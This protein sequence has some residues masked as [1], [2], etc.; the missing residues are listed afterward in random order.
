MGG[1]IWGFTG[2]EG[3]GKSCCMTG[4]ALKHAAGVAHAYGY[5]TAEQYCM[6]P[7]NRKPIMCFDGF[8]VH[9]K[10]QLQSVKLSK[11][12]DTAQW[13]G[14]FGADEFK[15]ILICIDEVQNVMDSAQS[16]SV[17]ARLLNHAMAQR[18]RAGLG[19][20]Y[21]LQS[22][23]WLHKRLRWST[24]YLSICKDLSRTAWGKANGLKKGEQ[25]HMATFDCKGFITGKEWA[26]LKA[27]RVNGPKV[28][29]HYDSFAPASLIETQTVVQ[30]R[31]QMIDWSGREQMDN[32]TPYED[33]YM[34][35]NDEIGRETIYRANNYEDNLQDFSTTPLVNESYFAKVKRIK[36]SRG[37]KNG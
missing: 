35:R 20:M 9:G 16:G 34:K 6:V 23:D 21:T 28:W 1:F 27:Y 30:K 32:L 18:R 17:F 22:W 7:E 12:I 31:V 10:G 3:S 15:N 37:Q 14:N 8:E 25:L 13:L 24:H 29:P 19:L 11:V 33:E 5:K 26:L 2:V 4:I 36:A